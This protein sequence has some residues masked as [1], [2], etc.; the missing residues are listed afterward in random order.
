MHRAHLLVAGEQHEGASPTGAQNAA[1]FIGGVAH[2]GR[3]ARVRTLNCLL[4]V[5]LA[6][7]SPYLAAPARASASLILRVRNHPVES[8]VQLYVSPRL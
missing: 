5:Y 2:E 1:D 3:M 7:R 8:P 4:T 6:I